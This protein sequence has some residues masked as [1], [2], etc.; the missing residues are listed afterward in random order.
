MKKYILLVCMLLAISY[1]SLGLALT[2]E[3]AKSQGLVGEKV[4]GFISA[5]KPVQN[6]E[7]QA[8]IDSTNEGRRKVY[9]QLAERNGITEEEVGI[10]SAEKLRANAKQGEYFQDI[11]G[12]WQ[13]VP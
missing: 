12:Q 9:A 11:T 13:R 4:D 2:L 5:V 3:E 6:E 1:S 8:L 7:L 10:L